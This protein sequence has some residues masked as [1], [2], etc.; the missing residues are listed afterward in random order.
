MPFGVAIGGLLAV[1][2]YPWLALWAVVPGLA[3]AMVSGHLF[4]SYLGRTP[5]DWSNALLG[6]LVGAAGGALAVLL[7]SSIAA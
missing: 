7:I 5:L 2:L 4:E 6:G 3:G 1:S